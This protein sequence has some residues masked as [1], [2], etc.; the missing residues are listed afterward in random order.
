MQRKEKGCY[1][2]DCNLYNVTATL[3][4]RFEAVDTEPCPGDAASHCCGIGGGFGH[5]GAACARLVIHRV[6]EVV[7]KPVIPDIDKKSR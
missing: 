4:G 3:A 7:A 1:A 6:T 2:Y 5:F